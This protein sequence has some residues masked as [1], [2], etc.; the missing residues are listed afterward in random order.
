VLDIGCGP[1]ALLRFL[2]DVTYIGIDRNEACIRQAQATYGARGRFRCE[3][4][5]EFDAASI[6]PVSVAV[7]IG[8]L[9]HLDDATAKRLLSAAAATLKPNG[10]LITADPCFHAGQSPVTRF[11][12]SHDRGRHVREFE[13]YRELVAGALAGASASLVTGH[14]PFPH[15]VCVVEARRP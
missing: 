3:D 4:V 8:V 5:A 11:V 15:A 1:G 14:L 10:R 13:R 2:P 7:A 12:V 9:H 6:P